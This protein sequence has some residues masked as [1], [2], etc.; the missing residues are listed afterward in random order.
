[1]HYDPIKETLGRFFNQWLFTRRLFYHL[2]DILLLRTWHIHKAVRGFF[3]EASKLEQV[4]VLDAGSGFGQYTYFLA[5]KKPQWNIHGID[6]KTDEIASCN[7]FF[8]KAGINNAR[9][10]EKDL[11]TY[12]ASNTYNLILSVDVME[13]ILEDELV[14]SNFYTS[15]KEGGM[16]LISTPSNLGGSDVKEAGD[17]SFIEEHV[18][19]GY[20]M[21]EISDKLYRAGFR[22]I[23]IQYTYGRPGNISWRLTMK[24]PI[25]LLGTSRLF[26]VIIPFYYLIVMPFALILNAAD[27]R[28]KHTSGTGLLVKAWK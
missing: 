26:F 13:H 12:L 1:M 16:L 6:I 8:Q 5:K 27:V 2:L 15:L 25:G 9:F 23:E 22:K 14:F 4:A 19:E 20:G 18:R 11:T 24:Y 17:T 10:E 3:I 21:Q 28:F 7:A